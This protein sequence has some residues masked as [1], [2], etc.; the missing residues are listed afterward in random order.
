MFKANTKFLFC[1]SLI[2]FAFNCNAAAHHDDD[3]GHKGKKHKHEVC[4]FWK[5]LQWGSI[6]NFEND[7]VNEDFI[8]EN[9]L[10]YDYNVV[11]THEP[12][13]NELKSSGTVESNVENKQLH[14]VYFAFMK[15]EDPEA[16]KGWDHQVSFLGSRSDSEISLEPINSSETD[17]VT[18]F[19]I[20]MAPN[21]VGDKILV[22]STRE[23]SDHV[24]ADGIYGQWNTGNYKLVF[25]PKGTQHTHDETDNHTC[26]EE[27]YHYLEHFDSKVKGIMYM[28]KTDDKVGNLRYFFWVKNNKVYL[29]N[30]RKNYLMV[31][32]YE[33]SAD[34]KNLSFVIKQSPMPKALVKYLKKCELDKKKA[35]KK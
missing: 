1:L 13:H 21:Q 10:M 4:S 16:R 34:G 23:E 25:M 27:K 19:N 18:P 33:L 31:L 20:G 32:P 28:Y 24:K 7:H 8:M 9:A 6:I 5:G 35:K 26:L 17:S 2:A 3:H 30:K 29:L 12:L 15:P 11:F 14:Y 22:T